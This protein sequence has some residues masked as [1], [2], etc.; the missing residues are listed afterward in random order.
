MIEPLKHVTVYHGSFVEVQQPDLK[1]CKNGKDF[2]RGFYVTTDKKQAIKFAKLVAVRHTAPYGVLNEY[3]LS[4][5]NDLTY[6][7]FEN[8][9]LDWLHCV[10]GN[11]RKQ[12][13][14]LAEKWADYDMLFGKVANDDTST[15]INAYLLGIYGEIGSDKAGNTAI[16]NLEPENLKNQLCLRTEKAIE[17][18]YFV[19]SEKVHLVKGG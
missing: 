5:I 13:K 6:C 11:R 14:H 10:V 16:S 15:V 12:F 17:K 8:T 19:K 1:Q 2:G 7:A 4:D 9:D 18:L 3:S